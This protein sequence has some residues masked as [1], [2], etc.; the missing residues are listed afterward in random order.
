VHRADED[1]FRSV[2]AARSQSWLWFAHLITG[3]AMPPKDMCR[4]PSPRRPLLS[5][6]RRKENRKDTSAAPSDTRT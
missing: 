2:V 1:D 3:D 6:V 4:P 5:R